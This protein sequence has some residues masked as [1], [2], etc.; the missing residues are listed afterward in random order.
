MFWIKSILIAAILLAVLLL[1][2][3]FSTL[4]ADPVTVNYLLGTTSLPLSL[5]VVCAFA[6]GVAV[7]A[8]VGAFVVL[9]LRWQV[10]RFRQLVTNKD[11]EIN[12]LSKKTGRDGR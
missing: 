7:T 9:P 6:L 1:G 2:L 10:A 3:E 5:V 11:H 4:H 8:M 12:M